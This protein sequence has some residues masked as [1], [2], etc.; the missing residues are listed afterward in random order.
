MA[1][2]QK[3]Q[4]QYRWLHQII[5]KYARAV[6]AKFTIIVEIFA[7]IRIIYEV[8][9]QYVQLF[10][11]HFV[12]STIFPLPMEITAVHDC[13]AADTVHIHIAASNEY[14]PKNII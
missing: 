13:Q 6:D 3:W 2:E 4:T 1:G 7:K 10:V 12:P 5:A 8:N 14:S 9:I 11:F